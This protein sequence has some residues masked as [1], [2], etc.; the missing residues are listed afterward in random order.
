MS[1]HNVNQLIHAMWSTL[2]QQ[3]LIPPSINNELHA[4]ITTVIKSKNGKVFLT[5]GSND[6]VHFLFLLPPE[7][8]LGDLLRHVKA[9][10]SKWIKSR[11]E[12]DPEFSWQTGYFATS[13]QKSRMDSVCNYIRTDEARH[14]LKKQNYAEELRSMLKLQNIEYDEKYFQQN[15][16]S[17]VLVHAVWS[18]CNRVPCLDRS[19]RNNLYDHIRS[20][21]SDF[22]GVVLEIGGIED[23]VHVFMEVP[24]DQALSD[25]M[26]EIKTSSTHWLK[27]ADSSS[28]KNFEWQ[29][30]YAGFTVSLAHL[31]IVK[32]Y[33]QQQEEHHRKQTFTDEW[34]Q[35][36]LKN[37]LK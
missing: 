7:L 21:V 34:D 29:T 15:S 37:Y 8:S 14:Q 24:R 3:Y 17:R 35:F 36:L 5:G 23:H 30:G 4:Y 18:T 12:I 27:K 11:K 25:A 13:T 20:V 32:K 2:N 33:I 19:L 6:H 26:R 22:R 9:H 1:H 16:F 31:E 28:Y 10:S